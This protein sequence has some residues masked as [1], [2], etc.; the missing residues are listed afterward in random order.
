MGSIFLE[1]GQCG[2]QIGIKLNPLLSTSYY[3]CRPNSP[4][5]VHAIMIDTEPKVLYNLR[6][7]RAKWLDV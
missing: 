6:E 2:C 5:R 7:K 1:A 3:C 4:N